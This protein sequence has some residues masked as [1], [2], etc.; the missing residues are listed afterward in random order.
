[1]KTL[2]AGLSLLATNA[3]AL[4]YPLEPVGSQRY[5]IEVDGFVRHFY[6]YAP[7]GRGADEPLPIVLAYHGLGSS[8]GDMSVLAD[9]QDHADSRGFLL[10]F[11]EAYLAAQSGWATN[12]TNCTPADNL[13]ID[14]VNFTEAIIAQVRATRAVDT[15]RIYATGFSMGGWFVQVLACERPDLVA[16]IAPVAA[17]MP[18]PVALDCAPE[19]PVGFAMFFS[20][21][22]PT[23]AWG[24]TPGAFG[25]L[26]ADSTARHWAEL[27][28][29]D[30]EPIVIRE[31]TWWPSQQTIER[32]EWRGCEG[33]TV[34]R[35]YRFDGLPHTWPPGT[36]DRVLEMLW[37]H[38]RL[39]AGP[40]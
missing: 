7:K 1:M 17:L 21:A 22:D 8:P 10:I 39:T 6:L 15:T 19:L 36:T 26:G 28:G 11:P 35:R 33:G 5:T 23:Q 29:C 24:G 31:P 4:G 34:V 2:F 30:G 18:R 12:C 20:D 37:K 38:R 3:C 16:A 40:S 14:D 13:G 9:L 25:L 27:D 32:R